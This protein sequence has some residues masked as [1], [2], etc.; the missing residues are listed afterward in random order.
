M[1]L[2]LFRT[3]QHKRFSYAPRYWDERKEEIEK[4]RKRYQ[5]ADES[6]AGERARLMI[7]G[8][9]KRRVD[10]NTRRKSSAITLLVYVLLIAL[11]AWYIFS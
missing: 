3:P 7:R 10:Q 5:A 2:T 6:D 9:W 4:I 11:L 1:R 8:R